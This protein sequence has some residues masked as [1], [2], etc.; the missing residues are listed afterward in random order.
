MIENAKKALDGI[1]ALRET[2][3]AL[4]YLQGL[5]ILSSSMGI[6]GALVGFIFD[7]LFSGPDPEILKL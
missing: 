5:K 7:F 4:K 2:M 6:V 1:I 3:N